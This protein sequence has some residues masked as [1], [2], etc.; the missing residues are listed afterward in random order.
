MGT[1]SRVIWMGQGAIVSARKREAEEGDRP[2][3]QQATWPRSGD[4]SDAAPSPGLPAAPRR[5]GQGQVP[6]EPPV[7]TCVSAQGSRFQTRG[8]RL[9]DHILIGLSHRVCG[10]LSQ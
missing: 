3:E 2:A 6:L 9:T 8:L 5:K 4:C 1:L 10:R 7:S